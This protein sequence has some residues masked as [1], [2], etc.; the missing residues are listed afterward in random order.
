MA[1][2]KRRRTQLEF[3]QNNRNK[4]IGFGIFTV[5]VVLILIAG[6][7]T[8]SISTVI[9]IQ[10][11]ISEKRTILE[12][13]ENKVSAL[14]ALSQQYSDLDY[15]TED[16]PLLFPNTGDYSLIVANIEAILNDY[17]FDLKVISFQ[18]G[19]DDVPEDDLIVLIK[20]PVSITMEGPSSNFLQLLKALEDMPMH[21]EISRVNYTYAPDANGNNGYSIQLDLYRVDDDLFYE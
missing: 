2:E 8:P 16:L 15:I 19:V 17:G 13:L 3:L 10:S 14:S 21:P 6:A 12:K 1:N 5:V 9:K 7:I 11:E 20:Q 4:A 18:D